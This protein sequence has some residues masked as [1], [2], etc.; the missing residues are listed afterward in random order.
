VSRND[1]R[2][3]VRSARNE[4]SEVDCLLAERAGKKKWRTAARRATKTV[5]RVAIRR[6]TRLSSLATRDES[7]P[8]TA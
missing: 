4:E 3:D 1:N 5:R 8:G 2:P 6:H 7:P